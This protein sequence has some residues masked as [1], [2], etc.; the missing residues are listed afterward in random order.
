MPTVMRIGPYRFFFFA[1]EGSEPRHIHVK[2]GE[3]EAKFWLEPVNLVW[4]RGFNQR[5]LKQI[6]EHIGNN[7]SFLITA[8]NEFF[9]EDD[10]D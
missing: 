7:L 2:S 10:R 8:W 1:N 5:Q 4:S 6:E 3:S 9:G